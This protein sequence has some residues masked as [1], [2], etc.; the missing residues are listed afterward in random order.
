[1]AVQPI[2]FAVVVCVVVCVCFVFKT[3]IF[4][5]VWQGVF[6]VRRELTSSVKKHKK[7]TQTLKMVDTS[8][9]KKGK[10]KK[11]KDNTYTDAVNK[12]DIVLL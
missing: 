2:V 11:E 8:K 6:R 12:T 3:I 4:G 1:M 7:K 5:L 10:K 9:K